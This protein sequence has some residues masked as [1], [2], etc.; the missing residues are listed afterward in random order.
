MESN[1][2]NYIVPGSFEDYL[3]S[4]KDVIKNNK[5]EF[6]KIGNSIKSI[7]FSESE[8]DANFEYFRGCYD[9]NDTPEVAIIN[10]KYND[11]EL[12]RKIDRISDDMLIQEVSSRNLEYRIISDI[13]TDR[14][15][16]ELEGRWNSKLVKLYNVEDEDLIDE[17]VRRGRFSVYGS[18]N[19]KT[20]ICEALGLNNPFAYTKEDIITE[21]KKLF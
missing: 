1:K 13:D 16:D 7:N 5:K 10:L 4:I 17:L 21:I 19:A 11:D 2:G 12:F 18:Q 15:E 8:V 20:I 9:S 3:E 6:N 14:L